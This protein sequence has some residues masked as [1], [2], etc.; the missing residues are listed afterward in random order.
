MS[1]R[2]VFYLRIAAI[3]LIMLLMLPVSVA[4]NYKVENILDN[5]IGETDSA[6]TYD[7]TGQ[8]EQD[9]ENLSEMETTLI[10]L[11]E[12]MAQLNASLEYTE[13]M[14]EAAN[15]T[16]GESDSSISMTADMFKSLKMMA[17]VLD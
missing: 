3:L 13:G 14:M 1:R 7:Q 15:S 4:I 10:T 12:N 8:I 17:E 9:P 16:L 5:K 11:N 6:P 2:Q